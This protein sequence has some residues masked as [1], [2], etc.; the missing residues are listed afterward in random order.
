MAIE[1]MKKLASILFV[2]IIALGC[3]EQ[4]KE[5][6]KDPPTPQWLLDRI[7]LIENAEDYCKRYPSTRIYRHVW[8][9]KHYYHISSLLSSCLG[10]EVYEPSGNKAKFAGCD[11]VL[12]FLENRTD[13]VVIWDFDYERCGM[14]SPYIS[15]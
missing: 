9:G 8:E 10:C 14:K 15:R 2:A 5:L 6:P 12:E 4:P 1:S 13:E 3:A 11:G 7:E